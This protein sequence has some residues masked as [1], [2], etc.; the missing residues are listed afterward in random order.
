[1]VGAAASL[2][3]IV[4]VGPGDSISPVLRAQL[5]HVTLASELI[6]VCAN[7]DD[8]A[9]LQ[10]AVPASAGVQ[11]RFLVA[12]PGRATQQ[13]A[14]ARAASGR[15]MWFLHADSEL[16]SNTLPQLAAFLDR[17]EPALGFF[18]LRFLDDG[19]ACMAL[20]MLGAWLRSRWLR[21]PFGDQ[22]LLLPRA[23]FEQLGGFD[24]ALPSGEDHDLVWRARRAGLPLQPLHATLYTSARKYAQHG[25]L[26][27]TTAH[28]QT[29]WRQ[30]RRF[31]R[32]G[33]L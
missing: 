19:P 12:R 9:R 11:W 4:P 17:D 27:T 30:A 8:S 1:M 32:A 20:N 25:W 13:N 26:T 10:A 5:Q 7:A 15:W 22:G 31:S 21:L 6:V 16:S 28:L 33:S 23:S 3:V 29:T 24:A 14:G 2:S 18:D